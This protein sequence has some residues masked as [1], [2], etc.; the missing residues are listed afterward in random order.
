[1]DPAFKSG[2]F[3]AITTFAFDNVA[4]PSP[5]YIQRDD[6]LFIEAASTQVGEIFT[7]NWRTLLAPFPR[8]GQPDQATKREVAGTG[9]GSNIIESSTAIL[10]VAVARTYVSR[11]VPL[12]E[13][14]LLSISAIGNTQLNRG[15]NFTRAWIVRGGSTSLSVAEVLFGDSPTQPHAVS[16]PGGRALHP[17]EGPGWLHTVTV[18]SPGAGLDWTLAAAANQRFRII[19]MEAQLAVANSGAPRPVEIILDDSVNTYGRMATNVAAPINATA[20]VN[21]SNSGTPSTSIPSDLYA[22][23]PATLMLP[24][25]HR[26]RSVTTNLVAGDSWTNIA[27]LV[28]EWMDQL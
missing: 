5:I 8:G 9:A 18:A 2:S 25:G 1:M 19:S 17:T 12:A 24:P 13:G 16:W 7:F 28:E 22:Q 6:V 3:P 14:Y 20:N 15:Q 27:F 23:M 10:T 26:I 4:P 11:F 21:F